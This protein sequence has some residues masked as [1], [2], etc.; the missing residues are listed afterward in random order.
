MFTVP[1]AT[2][3]LQRPAQRPGLAEAAQTVALRHGA[4]Y[5]AVRSISGR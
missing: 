4:R 5:G 3:T 2:A 1:F